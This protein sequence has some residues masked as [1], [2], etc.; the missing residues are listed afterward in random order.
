MLNCVTLSVTSFFITLSLILIVLL[1]SVFPVPAGAISILVLV[2]D[3]KVLPSIVILSTVTCGAFNLVLLISTTVA[4][5]TLNLIVLSFAPGVSSAVIF[6]SPSK[7][8]T[9]FSTIQFDPSYPSKHELSV[10]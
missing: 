4:P 7:S 3:V 6:V 8:C 9:P 10:L 2:A 1:K 5:A